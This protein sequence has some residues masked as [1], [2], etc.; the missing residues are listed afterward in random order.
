VTS[1]AIISIGEFQL[2]E[3]VHVDLSRL[4]VE[5]L[6]IQAGSGGGKSW[7]IRRLVEQVYGVGRAPVVL[8]DRE[9]EFAS[10]REQYDF[11]LAGK[12]GDTPISVKTA[13]SLARAVL[14][15]SCNI[16]CDLSE[17]AL[18]EQQEWVAA[19]CT[20][21]IEAPE[22]M[23]KDLVVVL[24]E[25]HLFAPEGDRPVSMKPVANLCS[26]GRK[27]GFCA[28]LATQRLSKLDKDV[29]AE[30]HNVLIGKTVLENDRKRAAETLDIP[31][32][33]RPEFFKAI[34]KLQP[35]SFYGYGNSISEEEPRLLKVGACV[36][37]HREPGARVP[38]TPP[39]PTEAIRHLLPRF[40]GLRSQAAK[41]RTPGEKTVYEAGLEADLE[42]LQKR[43]QEAEARVK[44]LEDRAYLSNDMVAAARRIGARAG[45]IILEASKI[46]PEVLAPGESGPIIGPIVNVG[47]LAKV[48]KPFPDDNGHRIDNGHR[49]QPPPPR[50]REDDTSIPPFLREFLKC[51]REIL[52][53]LAARGV[54]GATREY[55][56]VVTGYDLGGGGFQ[57]ALGKLKKSALVITEGRDFLTLSS[58]GEGLFAGQPRPREKSAEEV[59]ALWEEKKEVVGKSKLILRFLASLK[60][61][62][63]TKAQIAGEVTM[64]PGT[65]GF[66]NYMGMLTSKRLIERTR[67][68]YRIAS[69]L[70]GL[71]VLVFGLGLG[72][73]LSG[74]SAP[75]IRAPQHV[76]SS[77]AA[78]KP[79]RKSKLPVLAMETQ[80]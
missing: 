67:G 22:E 9:G 23:W 57:N 49:R 59:L 68:G 30:L 72:G 61:E 33:S 69:V 80:L 13:G 5:R 52:M 7:L 12:K 75:A 37:T 28:V 15:L 78:R 16:I 63:R 39:P 2:G 66:D 38:S 44:E 6:L 74:G 71:A 3:P 31:R 76:A 26:L 29:A 25:A 65:G 54:K 10:L 41:E 1:G 53:A 11:V 14:E 36:T 42:K 60:G 47:A 34:R 35:G 50:R 40:A 70:L 20:S 45:D 64:V 17:M 21:L 43:A 77:H 62:A 8:I 48:Q 27:R 73:M 4:L 24:D 79:A 18:E 56:A 19:F 51:E 58:K 32:A 55:V 46:A